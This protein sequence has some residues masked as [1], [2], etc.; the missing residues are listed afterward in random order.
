MPRACMSP[1]GGGSSTVV[2][3]AQRQHIVAGIQPALLRA[4]ADIALQRQIQCW[5]AAMGAAR[6]PLVAVGSAMGAT[7]SSL[8]GRA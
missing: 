6:A 8:L 2:A 7:R 1:P 5:P 4:P 3:G